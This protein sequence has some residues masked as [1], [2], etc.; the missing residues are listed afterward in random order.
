MTTIASLVTAQSTF[1]SALIECLQRTALILPETWRWVQY[2]AA[3]EIDGITYNGQNRLSG[4]TINYNTDVV[5]VAITYNG[6]GLVDTQ[7]F[8]S[9]EGTVTVTVSYNAGG[10]ITDTSV[11]FS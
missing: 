4:Y 3:W 2:E 7:S 10:N 9:A 1:R 11:S 8:T 5:T 6:Q